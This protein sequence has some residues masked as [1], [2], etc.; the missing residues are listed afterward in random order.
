MTNQAY[1]L[2]G[3]LLI[4]GTSIGEGMLGLP[5]MTGLGGLF[6]ALVV[7]FFCWLFMACPGL[8]FLEVTFWMHKGANIVSMSER[9]LG[10]PGKAFAWIMYLF[11]FY[12][13]TLAYTVGCGDLIFQFFRGTIPAWLGP[14][15]FLA[16]VFPL[17]FFGTRVVGRV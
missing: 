12:C 14:F 10:W 15:I 4:A 13:L 5:I 3:I 6:P 17:I 11:L 16:L 9:T 1:V 2:T 7:Y 8:L